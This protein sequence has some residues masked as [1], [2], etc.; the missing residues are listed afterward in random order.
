VTFGPF[1]ALV[2]VDRES[3][4]LY[5]NGIMGPLLVQST[6]ARHAEQTVR[7][8]GERLRA[9]AGYTGAFGVDGVIADS[10]FVAHE[11]N[12]RICAG[13]SL[14]NAFGRRRLP[15]GL[16]DLALRELRAD[17]DELLRDGLSRFA[18]KVNGPAAALRLWS[19][20]HLERQ[21]PAPAADHRQA[22]AG[23]QRTVRRV[24]AGP[25]RRPLVEFE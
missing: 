21:L 13:F 3:G 24:V 12:P 22:F 25:D 5:A 11:V 16:V 19:D 7:R 2:S 23:W 8:I 20:R 10:G 15:L 17:A 1:E 14:L 6:G 4:R 9:V 18:A